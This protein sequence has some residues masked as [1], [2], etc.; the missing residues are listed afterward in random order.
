MRISVVT[1]RSLTDTSYIRSVMEVVLSTYKPD[2]L[3]VL[4][5]GAPGGDQTV[6]DWCRDRGIDHI[7]FLPYHKLDRKAEFRPKY[8]FIRN[9]QLI[10][11]S[12][13]VVVIVDEEQT[14]TTHAQEYGE[15]KGKE[16]LT[17]SYGADQALQNILD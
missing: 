5:G 3:V 9:R 10:A 4:T 2:R 8:F 14:D 12:D 6:K 13:A 17:F 16:V 7:T 11:N 1:S 15:K